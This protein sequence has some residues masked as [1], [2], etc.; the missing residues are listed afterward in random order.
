MLW[1]KSNDTKKE[2]KKLFFKILKKSSSSSR[3]INKN[4]T[5]DAR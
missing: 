3:N 1:Q 4:L 2:L 5:F